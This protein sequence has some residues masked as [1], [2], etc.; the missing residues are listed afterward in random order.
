VFIDL[1]IFQLAWYPHHGRFSAESGDVGAATGGLFDSPPHAA[2]YATGGKEGNTNGRRECGSG[3]GEALACFR[4]PPRVAT[5][6]RRHSSGTPRG[7]ALHRDLSV[8]Q[9]RGSQAATSTSFH[10][11]GNVGHAYT[12]THAN[13]HDHSPYR[14][15]H[16][17][18]HALA[19]GSNV[20]PAHAHRDQVDLRQCRSLDEIKSYLRGWGN[21]MQARTE[22]RAASKPSFGTV[23]TANLSR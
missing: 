21:D 22:R 19:T 18:Y 6:S 9:A 16:N 23:S 5:S 17:V 4:T 1:T 20:Q 10:G 8:V 7:V 13:S 15:V 2:Y 3:G 14:N 12:H 11:F